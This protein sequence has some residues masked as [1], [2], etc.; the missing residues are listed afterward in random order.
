[1]AFVS[2]LGIFFTVWLASIQPS[3]PN[4]AVAPAASIPVATA[5]CVQAIA[6][7]PLRSP[8]SGTWVPVM[9]LKRKLS[10][11]KIR[12]AEENNARV[13]TPSRLL[14]SKSRAIAVIRNP[15]STPASCEYDAA[16]DSML[17]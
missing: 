10:S 15:P 7:I 5:P 9:R 13:C 4:R 8:S 1:M 2:S 11:I 17:H 14:R 6:Q 3:P 16:D 12:T